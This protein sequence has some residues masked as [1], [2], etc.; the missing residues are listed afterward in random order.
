MSRPAEALIN[1]ARS[2]EYGVCGFESLR[3][4]NGDAK[5]ADKGG[6]YG[7]NI[8]APLQKKNV[9]FLHNGAYLCILEHSLRKL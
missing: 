4:S 8:P 3:H 9:F 1:Q 6:A 7:R 5:D 2:Q